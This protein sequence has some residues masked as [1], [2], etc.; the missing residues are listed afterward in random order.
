[1]S[2]LV[3]R[4]QEV[5]EGQNPNL[6]T[7]TTNPESPISGHSIPWRNTGGATTSC[8]VEVVLLFATLNPKLEFRPSLL[9]LFPPITGC[10]DAEGARQPLHPH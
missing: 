3:K 6:L 5:E 10:P 9:G 8:A 4:A 2:G 1:M 7:Q